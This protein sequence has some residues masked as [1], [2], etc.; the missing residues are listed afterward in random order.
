MSELLSQ[1][2]WQTVPQ[3]RTCSSESLAEPQIVPTAQKTVDHC[4]QSAAFCRS[5]MTAPSH[6][7]SRSNRKQTADVLAA[8]ITMC[9]YN[10]N[11]SSNLI[12]PACLVLLQSSISWCSLL[13]GRGQCVTLIDVWTVVVVVVVIVIVAVTKKQLTSVF[14]FLLHRLHS[15]YDSLLGVKKQ[16]WPTSYID[17]YGDVRCYW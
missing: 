5:E 7:L 9:I 10:D 4:R 11:G 1:M 8:C 2:S 12:L 17:Y 14:P 15:G 13:K 6:G 16:T 3:S